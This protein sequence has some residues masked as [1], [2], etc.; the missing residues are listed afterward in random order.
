MGQ[1][2]FYFDRCFGKRF[3]Q[4]LALAKPPF[5]VEYH[6]SKSNN[7]RQEMDDDA[8]LDIVGAKG[9]GLCSVTT[10]VST[11]NPPALLP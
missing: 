10:V 6:H 1:L 2:T 7:F 3:P 8:W 11:I 5:S 9:G 4:A